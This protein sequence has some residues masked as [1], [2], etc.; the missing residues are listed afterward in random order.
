MKRLRLRWETMS[1]RA[2]QAGWLGNWSVFHWKG[3]TKS[4]DNEDR[5]RAGVGGASNVRLWSR[6]LVR[7]YETFRS[8]SGVSLKTEYGKTGLL[9]FC[10]R[11]PIPGGRRTR[12]SGIWSFW[13]WRCTSWT[14]PSPT[15]VLPHP[16]MSCRA[17]TA[18]QAWCRP[19]KSG[20]QEGQHERASLVSRAPPRRTFLAEFVRLMNELEGL[21]RLP[22]LPQLPARLDEGP[23][24]VV[25]AFFVDRFWSVL[26]NQLRIP[27][28][29]LR[30]LP[31]P[32]QLLLRSVYFPR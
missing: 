32:R 19:G 8:S 16:G 20:L 26:Q 9:T 1:V 15:P 3:F 29:S 12:S 31:R 25:T 7:V 11:W 13:L 2:L 10:S 22:F 4:V 24:E 14:R 23:A 30:H 27:V 17:R 18:S 21:F 6:T 28:P 5:S